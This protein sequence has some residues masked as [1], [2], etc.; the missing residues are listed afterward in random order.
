MIDLKRN[1]LKYI[2]L[3]MKYFGE[4]ELEFSKTDSALKRPQFLW[5]ML[6]SREEGRSFWSDYIG[7][8]ILIIGRW[9]SDLLSRG[10]KILWSQQLVSWQVIGAKWPEAIL[11]VAQNCLDWIH[12]ARARPYTMSS[13]WLFCIFCIANRIM[14]ISDRDIIDNNQ[15]FNFIKNYLF[16]WKLRK[17]RIFTQIF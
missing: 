14:I 10:R 13:V 3:K 11:A 17:W 6:Q 15:K 8:K 1:F 7:C 9:W 16:L 12:K 5:M 4:S 2:I